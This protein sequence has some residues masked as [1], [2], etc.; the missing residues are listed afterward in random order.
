MMPLWYLSGGGPIFLSANYPD[1]CE[2]M[3]EAGNVDTADAKVYGLGGVL[4]REYVWRLTVSSGGLDRVISEFELSEVSRDL[5]PRS[6]W[7]VFPFWWRPAHSTNCR[8]LSTP[9]FPAASRGDDGEHFFTMYE[10][11]SQ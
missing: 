11:E 2:R 3:I 10:P 4:D 9:N 7:G 6:F 1:G 5:V 8:Y